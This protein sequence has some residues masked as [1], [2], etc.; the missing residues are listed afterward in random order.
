MDGQ[1]AR[2]KTDGDHWACVD[3]H[4]LWVRMR[5]VKVDVDLGA[6]YAGW[7]TRR[8]VVL[9]TRWCRWWIRVLGAVLGFVTGFSILTRLF[10]AIPAR[11]IQEGATVRMLD[12]EPES[13]A[14][15]VDDPCEAVLVGTSGKAKGSSDQSL[16]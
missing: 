2:I 12:P 5:E 15:V 11:D 16:H 14:E 13:E 7:S 1:A 3:R 6:Y 8:V 10:K 9:C 4:G